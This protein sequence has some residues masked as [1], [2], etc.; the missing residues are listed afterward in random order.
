MYTQM[1]TKDNKTGYVK[2][3]HGGSS[4]ETLQ[5]GGSEQVGRREQQKKSREVAKLKE[6]E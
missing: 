6:E 4:T 3:Q 5:K 1:K 2:T